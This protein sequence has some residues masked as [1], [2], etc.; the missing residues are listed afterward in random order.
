MG[1]QNPNSTDGVSIAFA[2]ADA[3]SQ[4]RPW[5]GIDD[6]DEELAADTNDPA[7]T[8]DRVAHFQYGWLDATEDAHSLQREGV[9]RRIVDALQEHRARVQRA[10]AKTV[11]VDQ[12]DRAAGPV[13]VPLDDTRSL[14]T[15]SVATG[16]SALSPAAV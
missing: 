9:G 8:F 13:R 4:E 3:D 15:A 7:G 1:F 10:A 11:A 5:I 12:V 16:N 14:R 6:V 2:V